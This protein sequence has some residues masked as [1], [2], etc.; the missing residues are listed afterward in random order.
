MPYQFPGAVSSF[1]SYTGLEDELD[2]SCGGDVE[3]ETLPELVNKPWNDKRYEIVLFAFD[4]LSFL[5]SPVV[6]DR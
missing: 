6:F 4:C 2:E 5:W 3:D 1:R